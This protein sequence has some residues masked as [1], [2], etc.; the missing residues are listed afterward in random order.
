MT[1]SPKSLSVIFDAERA[2]AYDTQ[3]PA[4]H[5]LKDAVYLLLQ[6]QF[7][8]LPEN[9]RILVAGAGTGA[10]VRM[11]AQH[12]PGWHF[13]LVDPAEAMLAVARRHAEAEGFADRC[14]FYADYV[15]ATP[16]VAHDAATSLLV[17][18]FLME[19]SARQAFFADIAARLKPGGRLFT[20]DLCTDNRAASFD[21]VMGLWLDL[22]RRSGVPEDGIARYTESYGRDFAAHSPAE[23]HALIV[24]AGF[25]PPAPVFQAA[26]MRGCVTMRA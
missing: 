15:S 8:T 18:H 4:M 2:E 22:L 20:L 13:T 23:L 7:A 17:S 12:Y 6:V 26:L 24:A 19:P 5:A 9:A 1:N 14:T 11:L 21:A 16:T 25:A 10:E 3:F